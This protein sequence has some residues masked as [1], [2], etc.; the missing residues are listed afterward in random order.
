LAAKIE[1][2]EDSK[3]AALYALLFLIYNINML[4]Y[5]R[6]VIIVAIAFYVSA[7]LFPGVVLESSSATIIAALL[8]GAL[9][10][11]VRPI[12]VLLTL[13]IT[14]ITLGLFLL[15]INASFVY[16][17]GTL[18]DGFAVTTFG[19]ALGTAV[20]VSVTSFIVG[21]FS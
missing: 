14:I 13:P 5:F 8:L 19:A 20:V 7:Q 17:A 12:I 18:V 10:V 3:K 1:W 15:V 21:R 16:F 11:L 4:N 6:Q 2:S 9:N